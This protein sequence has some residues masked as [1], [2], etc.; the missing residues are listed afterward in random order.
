MKQF[1]VVKSTVTSTKRKTTVG[2]CSRR[3]IPVVKRSAT[4]MLMKRA[5]FVCSPGDN[6]CVAME[7]VTSMDESWAA[8]SGIAGSNPVA[9]RPN[10]S[11]IIQETM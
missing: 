8:R 2:V 7:A 9:N 10:Y 6:C 1:A 4:S 3:R 11:R 5:D